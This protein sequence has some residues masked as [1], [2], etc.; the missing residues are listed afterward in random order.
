[1]DLRDLV[2]PGHT[3]LCLVETQNGVVGSDSS[4]PVVAEAVAS[5]GLLERL[6]VLVAAAR[7][8]GVRVVHCPFHAHGDLWGGNRNSRLFAAGRRSEVQQYVGTD[9]V[10]PPAEIGFVMGSDVVVPRFH[11][12]SPV[13]GTG[14]APMLRNEGVSTVAVV[15]VSLNVAIPNAVFDLVNVGFQVVV[16]TDGS[17]ATE[18]GYGEQ[19]LEH[20]LAYVAT[21]TDVS[22]LVEVW[23]KTGS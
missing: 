21:L 3:A 22:T 16:P 18:P 7:S 19:V 17:V 14:L 9:A 1:M 5:A 4:V 12:L 6:G 10:E 11:G 15:G 13:S 8:A 2:E 20:T 23:S